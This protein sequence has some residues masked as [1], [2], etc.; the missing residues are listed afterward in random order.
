L[1]SV[2]RRK[3]EARVQGPIER[4]SNIRKKARQVIT[5]FTPSGAGS[6]D[7]QSEWTDEKKHPPASSR[8]VLIHDR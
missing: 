6:E 4:L 1:D 2:A 3:S 8:R 5:G 7:L